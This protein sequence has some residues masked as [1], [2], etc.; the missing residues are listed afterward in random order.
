MN[1]GVP[2]GLPLSPVL[3]LIYMAPI[4][5]DMERRLKQEI[6]Y[7]IEIPSYIDDITIDLVD[8]QR[9]IDMARVVAKAKR[10]AWEVAE[11]Y[12]LPLEKSKE[13]EMLFRK[14]TRKKKAERKWVNWLGIICDES[15]TF[16]LY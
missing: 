5:K 2:Q 14:T 8:W 1:I 13:E 10:I 4:I 12:R 3:F 6:D 11:E 16:E 15:L 7:D 9:G